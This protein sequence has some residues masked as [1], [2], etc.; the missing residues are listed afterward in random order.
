MRRPFRTEMLGA[1]VAQG[2]QV[3]TLE[4]SLTLAQ[5]DRGYGN[6]H[7]V[8]EAGTKVLL[9]MFLPRIQAPTFVKPRAAK[10]SSMPVAPLSEPKRTLWKVRVGN[11]HWCRSVPPT[12]SGLAMS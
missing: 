6:V 9:N 4:E 8:D 5:H 11:A 2:S 12:P 3:D 7:L 10:S 1:L